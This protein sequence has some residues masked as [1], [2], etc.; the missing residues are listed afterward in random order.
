[1]SETAATGTATGVARGAGS[2]GERVLV[3]GYAALKALLQRKFGG[4]SKVVKAVE[5]LEAE[6]DSQGRKLTLKEKVEEAKADL[7]EASP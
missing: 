1:M 3:D 4:E 7:E 6:P 5:D 2:V